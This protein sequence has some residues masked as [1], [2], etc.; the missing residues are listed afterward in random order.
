MDV[1]C[2][3]VLII[4]IL[5]SYIKYVASLER[6]RS[7]IGQINLNTGILRRKY[8]KSEQ[9][10]LYNKLGFISN[11]SLKNPIYVVTCYL[12]FCFDVCR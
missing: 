3:L 9:H 2:C 11:D 1:L 5:A 4:G 10:I 12:E 6:V 8:L 7:Y